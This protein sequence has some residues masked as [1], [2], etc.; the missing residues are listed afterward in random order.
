M[1]YVE[2]QSE[3]VRENE[4]TEQC[5]TNVASVLGWVRLRNPRSQRCH[6][7]F[8]GDEC[9]PQACPP[10]PGGRPSACIHLLGIHHDMSDS[11]DF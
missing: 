5:G 8:L 2:R 7:E 10:P 6:D 4:A 9:R 11:L 3:V 1:Y